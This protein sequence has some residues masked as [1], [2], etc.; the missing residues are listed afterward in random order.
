MNFYHRQRI[1]VTVG[2]VIVLKNR[3]HS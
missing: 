1:Q 3:P 2:A